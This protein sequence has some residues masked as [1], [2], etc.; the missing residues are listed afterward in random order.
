MRR[1]SRARRTARFALGAVARL[2]IVAGLLIGSYVAFE[3][4]GTA[5]PAARAQDELS[6]QWETV[7]PVAPATTTTTTPDPAAPPGQAAEPLVDASL[8]VVGEPVATIE[9]PKINLKRVVVEGATLDQLRRGPGHFASTPLPGQAGNAA[10]AGHR[11]TYGQPF[12]NVDK[13][14]PGDT[15]ETTSV[16][17]PATY[18][19]SEVKIVDPSQTEVLE[20]AGDDRLTLVACHPK[21]S[22]RQRIIVVAHLVD[23]PVPLIA[24]QEQAMV[25][26]ADSQADAVEE[27]ATAEAPLAR[28]VVPGLLLGVAILATWTASHLMWRRGSSLPART[29]PWLV[30]SPVLAVCAWVFFSRLVVP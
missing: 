14:E 3:L 15:I 2:A 26:A 8:P 16:L 29:V 25:D 7:E 5:I 22:A 19:V 11:T 28:V 27:M 21:Y 18:R 1:E 23:D 30:G 6:D 13:L 20:D 4:W 17:G 9:I 12:H 10:I 24:G